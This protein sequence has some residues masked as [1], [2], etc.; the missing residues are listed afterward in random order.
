[1]LGSVLQILSTVSTSFIEEEHMTWYFLWTSFLT[2]M[3]VRYWSKDTIKSLVTLLI[4]QRIL[5]KMNQTG[6]KWASLPDISDWFQEKQR[7]YYL[8]V[9]LIFGKWY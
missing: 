5:R 9:F 1:M 6:D 8:S 3:F 4:I 7:E 2:L